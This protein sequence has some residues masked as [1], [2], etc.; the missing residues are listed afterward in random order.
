MEWN[1]FEKYY[2]QSFSIRLVKL[3]FCLSL[4]VQLLV[5]T[6]MQYFEYKQQQ[7]SRKQKT[8]LFIG[9]LNYIVKLKLCISMVRVISILQ[10]NTQWNI[11]KLSKHG[12]KN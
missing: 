5:Q 6:C 9:T 12:V 10:M 1:L 3:L 8:T 11:A 4:Y 2:D 7:N